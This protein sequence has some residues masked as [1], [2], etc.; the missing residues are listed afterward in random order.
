MVKLNCT[1]TKTDNTNN[2]TEPKE[3]EILIKF[4]HD[5]LIFL[6]AIGLKKTKNVITLKDS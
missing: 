4:D 2:D 3:K 5:R 6:K 1:Y